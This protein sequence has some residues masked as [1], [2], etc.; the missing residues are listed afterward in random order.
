M[1]GNESFGANV[2]ITTGTE[3]A[4]AGQ[5]QPVNPGA[6]VEVEQSRAVQEVQAAMVIAKRFPRDEIV[7]VN[8]VLDACKRKSLAERAVYAY[9]RGG[10]MVTGP[11]IRLAE[12]IARYWGNLE[13]GMREISQVNGSST[14]EAY[15]WDKETN[16]RA[17]RTFE[18][19]H[20]RY[21]RKGTTHLND[22]RDIYELVANQGARRMR[23][24]IL[25]VVRGHIVD[26]AVE[27]CGLTMSGNGKDPIQDRARKMVAVFREQGVT[28]EMIEARIGHNLDA[29]IEAE[30]AN[31]RMIYTS[32][33]D[34]MS[35]AE[36]WF[37]R[38]AMPAKPKQETAPDKP[39]NKTKGKK[40]APAKK[41]GEKPK[42]EPEEETRDANVPADA[43]QIDSIKNLV[44]KLDLSTDFKMDVKT[45]MNAILTHE[46]G[47]LTFETASRIIKDLAGTPA[48]TASVD[49]ALKAVLG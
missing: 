33:R 49:K 20:K 48:S 27:E 17:V 44:E 21:T 38:D 11:S 2:P 47:G 18:V 31:L 19:A 9:P 1:N 45:I 36:D 25:E 16:V 12:A 35:K 14:M 24:C 8:K 43:L 7:A 37:D 10:Q 34:G 42:D 23:A 40:S 26:E 28:K 30:L 29:I 6:L 3:G 39:E 46:D 5:M 32:I 4:M 13:Y 22:P 15:C 41:A